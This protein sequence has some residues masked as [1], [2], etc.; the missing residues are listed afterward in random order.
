MGEGE[1]SAALPEYG[2]A[3]FAGSSFAKPETANGCSLAHRM[4]EG[5]GEGGVGSQDLFRN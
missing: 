1:S 3:E 4:G 2:A 5:Q